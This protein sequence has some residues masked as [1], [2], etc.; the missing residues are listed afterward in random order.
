MKLRSK[1]PVARGLRAVA[2]SLLILLACI[3]T[4]FA[5]IVVV[6]AAQTQRER[7]EVQIWVNTKSWYGKAKQGKYM[8]ECEAQKDGYHP[9]YHKP[10]GSNCK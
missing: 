5:P 2:L 3:P 10:Y 9:A 7:K 8:G 6:S 1:S 4:N